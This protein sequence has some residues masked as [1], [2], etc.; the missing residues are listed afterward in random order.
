MEIEDSPAEVRKVKRVQFGIL[1]SDEIRAMSVCEILQPSIF[2]SNGIPKDV[3]Y[4]LFSL[5]YY[6]LILSC[7]KTTIYSVI[8]QTTSLF[9]NI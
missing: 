3:R 6:T 9:L 4:N 2:D 8:T 7:T 5:L 1:S